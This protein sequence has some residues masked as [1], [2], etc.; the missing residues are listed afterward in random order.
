MI[1]IREKINGR[2]P[3]KVKE[4]KQKGKCSLYVGERVSRSNQ[5]TVVVLMV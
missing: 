3:E 2:Q 4:G 1:L 5:S